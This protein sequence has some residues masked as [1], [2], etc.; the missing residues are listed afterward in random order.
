MIGK[1]L[2]EC[3][4]NVNPYTTKK[5]V[6]KATNLMMASNLW[7]FYLTT[8]PISFWDGKKNL[9]R[10]IGVGATHFVVAVFFLRCV[11]PMHNAF[12]F[13]AWQ[14]EAMTLFSY[15][16]VQVADASLVRLL[17]AGDKKTQDTNWFEE[18]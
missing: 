15:G 1:S 7:F 11:S 3:T 14:F 16:M 12:Y 5:K 4:A 9:R 13:C 18:K 10:C 8:R 17:M 6:Y 2:T